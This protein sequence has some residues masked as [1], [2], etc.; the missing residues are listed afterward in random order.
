[1]S[2][3]NWV[4]Y[5]WMPLYLYERFHMSLSR[6]GFSATFYIQIGSVAGILLG[7]W[8]ADYFSSRT[9]RSRLLTQAGGL[10]AAA[11]FL[12]FVGITSSSVLLLLALVVFG[13]GRG[14]YDAN[15]MPVLCQIAPARLRST[16][17]GLFNF[18]GCIAGG[19]VAAAAGALKSTMGLG[20]TI[21]VTGMLLLG[22]GLLLLNVRVA[23]APNITCP[24]PMRQN[25]DEATS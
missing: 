22:A 12:L 16:G 2:M 7:G 8:L 23:T 11:P 17:Y 4:L 10:M 25:T 18:A 21:Q 13:V 20:P 3:S 15:C 24:N 9:Q 1:M 5:T 14:A 19:I 6:A